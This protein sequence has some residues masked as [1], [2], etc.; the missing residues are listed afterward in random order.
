MSNLLNTL[1]NTALIGIPGTLQ[2]GPSRYEPPVPRV[3][4]GI[5][6]VAMTTI[7]L[8]VSVILPAQMDSR[9]SEPRL[10]A[11]TRAPG[12]VDIATVTRIDVVAARER[13]DPVD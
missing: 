1:K 10:L 2:V 3:A 11:A 4:L 6:G 13:S 7:T 12:S 8:A 9:R 5:A